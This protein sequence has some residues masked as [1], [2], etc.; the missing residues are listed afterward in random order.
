MDQELEEMIARAQKKLLN[1]PYITCGHIR[2]A[3]KERVEHIL[4]MAGIKKIISLPFYAN[5]L[6]RITQPGLRSSA[7]LACMTIGLA[8]W[9]AWMDIDDLRDRDSSSSSTSDKLSIFSS[10]L[11]VM[12]GMASSL[13]LSEENRH[14]LGDILGRMEQANKEESS[15]EYF[16][17]CLSV[18]Q[19]T[20][21]KSMGAAL[22]MLIMLMSARATRYDIDHCK[23]Y[24]YYLILARQLS[25]D[26]CDWLEDLNNGKKTLITCWFKRYSNKEKMNNKELADL[27]ESKIKAKTAK[28]ILRYAKMSIVSARKINCLQSAGFLEELPRHYE[29]MAG[30]ILR[31]L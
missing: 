14:I 7:I 23:N 31:E 5:E 10:L 6:I 11:F 25:D 12:H 22:P 9:T 16:D 21:W 3:L 30:R 15:I 20:S 26:A 4:S 24:F 19:R 18:R 17:D 29:E 8:G 27:F 28:E 2:K 1:S 13:G